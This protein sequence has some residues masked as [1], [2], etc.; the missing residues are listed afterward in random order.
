MP[1]TVNRLLTSLREISEQAIQARDTQTRF[2]AVM[3]HELRTPL[4]SIVN[5]VGLVDAERLPADQRPLLTLVQT[6]AAVLMSRVDDV[7]DVAAI[8]GGSLNLNVAPF[9]VR[10]MVQ[11]VRRVVQSMVQAKDV[12]FDVV[13]SPAVPQVLIGDARRIEQVV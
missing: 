10:G 3:S 9:E 7:L 5:A 13:V 1:L 11:T 2:L 4:N 8:D 6:N 12:V